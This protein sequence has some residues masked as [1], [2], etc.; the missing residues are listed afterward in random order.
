MGLGEGPPASGKTT[1]CQELFKRY[2]I[3][4]LS[5]DDF[6]STNTS[7]YFLYNIIVLFFELISKEISVMFD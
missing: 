1:L 4:H 3:Q 2:N 7:T 6:L 5:M